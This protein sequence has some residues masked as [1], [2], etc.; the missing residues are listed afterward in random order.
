MPLGE[1]EG[2]K[3]VGFESEIANKLKKL[4]GDPPSLQKLGI[5]DSKKSPVEPS[6]STGD[7]KAKPTADQLRE[8]IQNL[9]EQLEEVESSY[10]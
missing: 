9:Q 2:I 5:P 10:P 8:Q 3:P 6:V 4:V 7:S 1:E